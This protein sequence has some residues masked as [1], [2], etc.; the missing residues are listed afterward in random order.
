MVQ[1]TG[2]LYT[3][4]SQSVAFSTG[5]LRTNQTDSNM[6]LTS[7]YEKQE[8]D[9]GYVRF[10]TCLKFTLPHGTAYLH[11]GLQLS[12]DKGQAVS[13]VLSPITP[14]L[15]YYLFTQSSNSLC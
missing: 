13:H 4:I 9:A 11:S 8:Y 1:W 10:E 15:L 14:A 7:E 12:S 2:P 6:A 3:T 5:Y